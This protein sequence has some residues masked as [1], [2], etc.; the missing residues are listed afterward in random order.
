MNNKSHS[1]NQD[2]PKKPERPY[3]KVYWLTEQE[4]S[5]LINVTPA[6][7]QNWRWKGVGLPYIRF[8]R[9]VRYKE[10]DVIAYMDSHAVKVEPELT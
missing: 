8:M 4:V 6:T 2:R 1:N 7:L 5:V 3:K 9:S 10:S